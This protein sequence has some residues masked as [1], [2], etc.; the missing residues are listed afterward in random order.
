MYAAA[1]GNE[2][3]CELLI[4]TG[5]KVGMQ[6]AEGNTALHLA[7]RNSRIQTAKLLL[8]HGARIEARNARG[9]RAFELV[10]FKLI[11]RL[12]IKEIEDFYWEYM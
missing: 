8:N 12:G 11:K 10:D 1:N 9:Q 6:N 3:L 4:K 5:A 2:A 7:L